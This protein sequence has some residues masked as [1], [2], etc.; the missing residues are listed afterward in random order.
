MSFEYGVIYFE[1]C[2]ISE[3][4]T[5]NIKAQFQRHTG[6]TIVFFMRYYLDVT[7][8]C[9][10]KWYIQEIFKYSKFVRFLRLPR[11][12]IFRIFVFVLLQLLAQLQF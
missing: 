8:S 2:G 11:M 3:V 9:L 1:N 7:L 4:T 10:H 5:K 6:H 12:M